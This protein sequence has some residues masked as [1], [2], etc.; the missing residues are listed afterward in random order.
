VNSVIVNWTGGNK[1]ILTL[2]SANQLIIVT[3][4]AT[5]SGIP[6]KQF[7]LFAAGGLSALM[8]EKL[9]KNRL[10]QTNNY[11]TA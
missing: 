3:E 6:L 9:R 5:G 2:Q 7:L 4:E 10:R 11:H 1:Q 8:F